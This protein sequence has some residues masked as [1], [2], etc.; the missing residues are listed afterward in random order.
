M[1]VHVTYFTAWVDENGEINTF[2]DVYGH[3]KRIVLGLEG[4]WGEIVKNR[5]HLLPPEGSDEAPQA[6]N[7]DDWGDNNGDEDRPVRRSR[8]ARVTYREPP[9]L[10][11]QQQVARKKGQSVGDLL[12]KMFGGY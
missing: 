7:R 2:A 9:P 1:P 11:P 8:P 3:E 4:R 12:Q 5:D 10:P 6:R